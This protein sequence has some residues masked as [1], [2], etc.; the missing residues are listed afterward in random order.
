MGRCGM[1]RLEG[2]SGCDPCLRTETGGTRRP[3]LIWREV[4]LAGGVVGLE[5]GAEVASLDQHAVDVFEG[6]V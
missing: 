4:A 2:L 3:G 6:E 1:G 5:G